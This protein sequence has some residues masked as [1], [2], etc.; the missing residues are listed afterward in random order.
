MQY[1]EPTVVDYGDLVSLT[2]AGAFFGDEDGLN[3][4]APIHH[5]LA[6]SP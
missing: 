3:K 1:E 2:A 6:L 5:S 4:I